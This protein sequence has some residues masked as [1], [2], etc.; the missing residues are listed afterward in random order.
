M[1]S[2]RKQIRE[3]ELNDRISTKLKKTDTTHQTKVNKES[4][5]VTHVPP[6]NP[7]IGEAVAGNTKFKANLGFM[8]RLCLKI[9]K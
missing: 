7:T 4:G 5:M 6:L 2:E 8:V 1:S 9:K 3:Y